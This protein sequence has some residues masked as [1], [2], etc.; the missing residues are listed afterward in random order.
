MDILLDKLSSLIKDLFNPADLVQLN[1]TD[2]VS[3]VI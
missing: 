3:V 2:N 1:N